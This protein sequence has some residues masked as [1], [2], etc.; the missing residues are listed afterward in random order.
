MQS[1]VL[2]ARFVLSQDV[3]GQRAGGSGAV[4]LDVDLG[5]FAVLNHD[6]EPLAANVPQNGSHIKVNLH[7]LFIRKRVCSLSHGVLIANLNWDGY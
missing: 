6:G 2:G 3:V 1:R 7:G 4:R 5:G